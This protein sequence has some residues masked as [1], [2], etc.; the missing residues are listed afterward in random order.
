MLEDWKLLK[1]AQV[2]ASGPFNVMQKN[3]INPENKSDFKAHVLDLPDWVNIIGMND[4]GNILLIKQY[5]FGTNSI[6]LEIPG[7]CVEPDE[8]PEKAAIRELKEETGYGA[9]KI[10]CIGVVDANPAIMNNKCYSFLAKIS[11]KGDVKLDPNEI[12]ET[13][14][15]TPVRVKKYLKE[16]KITNAYVIG[17]FLW[18]ALY[19][20][21]I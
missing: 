15:A 5:R 14:F 17:A 7:G 12:I 1:S 16:G 2:F 8:I 3:Y 11:E 20:D 10:E 21:K 19:N 4:E 13:E 9:K 18:F 6:S